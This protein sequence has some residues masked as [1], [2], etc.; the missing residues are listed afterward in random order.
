MVI[1]RFAPSPSGRMHFGNIYACLISYLSAKKSGGRWI[2]R[3][4]DLDRQRCKKEYSELLIDDLHW[5]GFD[6]DE[7]PGKQDG[8]IFF[9]SQRNALYEEF[10][11]RLEGQNLIYD[12][13]CTRSDLFSSSAPHNSDGTPVYLG[14]CRNLSPEQKELLL[15][16]KNP[17]KRIFVPDEVVSF[18]DGHYGKQEISL[19]KDAGDFIVRRADGNFPYNLAVV[20]DDALMGVNEIVRG[21]DLLSSTHQQLYLYKKLDFKIPEFFHIPLI[22]NIEGRRL[23]KRDKDLDMGFLRANFSR[24]D[25]IGKIMNLCGFTEKI[26][27]MSLSEA[28]SVF[29]K[30]ALPKK[31]ILLS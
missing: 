5:L 26:E 22:V 12:C 17:T 18:V 31:D 27:K 23:S 16:K 4:E 20:V 1:G 29:D 2:L 15:Q 24:E 7:G 21:R 25:I 30:E 8:E 28:I 14:R 19:F 10:F 13:F 3:I 9:Q 11:H 6:W